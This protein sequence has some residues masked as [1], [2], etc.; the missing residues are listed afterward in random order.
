MTTTRLVDDSEGELID[1]M[2][3]CYASPLKHVLVSY[4]WGVK[5]TPL[6]GR[7]GPDVWQ[8]EFLIELGEEVKKRKFDGSQSVQPIQFST[9]SGHGI[10]KSCLSAWIVIWV[11][12]TRPQSMGTI[13]ATTAE[14]LRS[15]TFG[16][17]QKWDSMSLTKHWFRLNAGTAGSLNMYHKDDR[18]WGCTG[19]TCQENNSEAFA[20][21]HRDSSTSYY[22]FDEASGVPDTIYA[23]REGGL[24]DGEPM[25]FDFGNPTRNSGQF[26]ANMVGK[27]RRRFIKRFI[28]SRSVSITNKEYLNRMIEDHGIDSDQVKVRVLGQFPSASTYQFISIDDVDKAMAREVMPAEY[29]FAPTIIGVDPAWTGDDD[30]VIY[31][32]QGLNSKLLGKYARNDNDVQMAQLIAQFEDDYDADAVFIDGG[33]GTGIVS[34]GHTMG[35]VEWQIVWF[36]DKSMDRGCLNKRA[37]MWDQMRQWIKDG[38][39]LEGSETMRADLTGV[40]LVPRLDGKKQLESKEHMKQRGLASPNEADALAIT[41]AFPVASK[42]LAYNPKQ[43]AETQHEYDPLG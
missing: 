30:F 29:N 11:R 19:Q 7:D 34:I 32:R 21:Q 16:E 24:T 22:I 4:P 42:K 31:M 38:G 8:R 20:G 17:L 15:R 39:C 37:E 41:F 6:E 14:Q 10:G 28:D 27:F 18:T 36:G 2:A 5:G 25:T 43:E 9:S 13:T 26:H 1:L 23:V 33:F 35:R 40:E 3:S 12:D